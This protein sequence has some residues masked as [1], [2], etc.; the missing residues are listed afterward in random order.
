MRRL[1][2][3]IG[4]ERDFV[5]G[6]GTLLPIIT[7]LVV[8]TIGLILM[9]IATVALV[10][11]GLSRELARFQARSAFLGVG[12]T[13]PEAERVMNH[14]VR[15]SI[16]MWLMLVGNAGFIAAISSIIPVFIS[17]EES[18]GAFFPKVLALVCGLTLLWALASSKWID[19]GMSRVIAWALK[20]WTR[21]EVRDY[22]GLLQ[23]SSGY[24]VSELKVEAGDWVTGKTLAE[25]RLGDE[26]VQILGIRRASGQ[27]VGAPT[28]TTGIR[29][30]DTLILYGLVEHLTEL[31][32][33]RADPNG[34]VV[35]AKRVEELRQTIFLQQ[36]QEKVHEAAAEGKPGDTVDL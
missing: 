32:R 17:S 15:R 25:L 36:Q 1:Y 12:F 33:R 8:V 30:G 2:C 21:L 6:A 28:G 35:H 22:Q 18:P 26:G 20:R 29:D 27:Y 19:R 4:T 34:D 13:T 9:R 5:L 24:T 10:F 7:L 23:L 16:I 3:R 11:T 14:P 31:D